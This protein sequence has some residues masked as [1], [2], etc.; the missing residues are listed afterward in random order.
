MQIT[1]FCTKLLNP[2][3]SVA[4]AVVAGDDAVVRASF[5]VAVDAAAVVAG[6]GANEY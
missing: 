2:K 1:D 3:R 5:D 6:E 4:V